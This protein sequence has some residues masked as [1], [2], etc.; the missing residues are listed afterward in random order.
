VSTQQNLSAVGGCPVD[1]PTVRDQPLDPPPEIGRLRLSH[2]LC[3]LRY[4]DGEVGWLATSYELVR[5]I[6]GDP[7]FAVA[8]KLPVGDPD[9]VA[10]VISGLRETGIARAHL[11][12]LDPPEHTRY[13]RLLARPFSRD[14]VEVFRPA[15]HRV[16]SDA[17]DAIE[18]AQ[19]PIDLVEMYASPIALASHCIAL[20]VPTSD[21]ERFRGLGE[22][23]FDPATTLDDLK[24]AFVEFCEY[25]RPAI[26]EKRSQPGDD[27]LSQ[28]TSPECE[29]SDEEIFSIAAMLFLAGRTTMSNMLA[30]G[31]FALLSNRT[32]IDALSDDPVSVDVAVD[33]LLRYVS[34]LAFGVTRRAVT[35]VELGGTVIRA[36]EHVTAAL[37]GANRDASKWD[38]PDVLDLTRR[39]TGHVAFGHGVHVCLGQHLARLEMRIALPELVKRFPSLHLAVAATEVP[40]YSGDQPDFGV[41]RLSMAW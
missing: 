9:Q 12:F 27:V 21:G 4:P 16:V 15:I 35:D 1:M 11:L 13:R 29:L 20:G 6:H 14:G 39:A 37:H 36:G 18:R 33:E 7:R 30:A 32:Q 23:L 22:A 28:V 2:P 17:L 8:E 3:R 5:A 40:L 34:V 31:L 19:P 26:R 38:D 25:L 24:E 10:G 41:H